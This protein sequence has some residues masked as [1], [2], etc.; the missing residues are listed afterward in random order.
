MVKRL[1]E[2]DGDLRFSEVDDDL[3]ETEG[4]RKAAPKAEVPAE[5]RKRRRVN[6]CFMAG[7]TLSALNSKR[8]V[9]YGASMA[10]GLRPGLN[11]S[12]KPASLGS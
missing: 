9:S 4:K 2:T 10:A 11:F 3:Q 12:P 6:D 8:C 1:S 5:E 7:C